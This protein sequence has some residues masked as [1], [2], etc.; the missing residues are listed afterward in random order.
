MECSVIVEKIA[1][2]DKLICEKIEDVKSTNLMS[3]KAGMCLYLYERYLTTR[4][5]KYLEMCLN[6]LDNSFYEFINQ[7]NINLTYSSGF[8]GIL[9]VADYIS[10]SEKIDIGLKKINAKL[11]NYL[12]ENAIYYFKK[13]NYDFLHGGL[14]VS[15]YLLNSNSSKIN[16]IV[17]CLLSTAKIIDNETVAWK[18]LNN[19]GAMEYNLGLS[20]GIPSIIVFLSKCIIN[21]VD[22]KRCSTFLLKTIRFIE[23]HKLINNKSKYSYTTDGKNFS[24]LA[25]CYGDLGV[26]RSFFIA[27]KAMKNDSLYFKSISLMQHISKRIDLKE[28]YVVD[29]S[30]CHGAAGIAHIFNL[31]HK[32]TNIIEFKELTDYWIDKVIELGNHEDGNVGYKTWYGTD[33]GWRDEIGF[34]EGLS[35]IGIVLNSYLYPNKESKWS[36]FLLLSI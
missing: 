7:N 2:I 31:F 21:G 33:T 36:R 1:Q 22:M 28:N 5:P 8:S 25:W 29:A 12:Y 18:S 19:K 35:G 17:D 6:V 23:N 9:D 30:L 34:L 20:H 15:M 11:E 32:D 24:R 14:G 10:K 4:L 16:S 3:G 27:S 26:A 13:N